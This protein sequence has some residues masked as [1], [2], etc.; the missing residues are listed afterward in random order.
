VYKTTGN[1][2]SYS[3]NFNVLESG[4]DDNSFLTG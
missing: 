1:I 3:L 4:Q 2:V